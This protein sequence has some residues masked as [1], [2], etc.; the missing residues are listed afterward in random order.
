[1][2]FGL[3][4][5]APELT[6]EKE[7]KEL[8]TE[9][10]FALR[11]QELSNNQIIQ[12]LQREGYSSTQI[13]DAINQAD[14]IG[15][16]GPIPQANYPQGQPVEQPVSQPPQLPDQGFPQQ[17]LPDQGYYA[18]PEAKANSEEIIEAI[19]EEKWNELMRDINRIIEWKNKTETKIGS[20]E[21][22]FKDLKDNFDKLHSALIGKI[23]E[24]DKNIL[25]V[26]TE[27]KAME[28]VF[29]KVLPTFTSTVNELSRITTNLKKKK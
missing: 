21:Q 18:E 26:G 3:R 24:Y 8:P 13:L 19:I 1:M 20:L 27:I 23:G 5:S 16:V 4:K 12:S 6:P 9:Q 28:K 29:Q 15:G 14:T 25:E 7:Q 2:A 10:V 22:E 11:Q 17:G